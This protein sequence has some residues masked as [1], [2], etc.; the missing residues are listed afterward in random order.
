MSRPKIRLGSRQSHNELPTKEK[1][2]KAR[3][4]LVLH[5]NILRLRKK[6]QAT[7]TKIQS[8][9]SIMVKGKTQEEEARLSFEAEDVLLNCVPV[10]ASKL[11]RLTREAAVERDPEA[12]VGDHP[13]RKRRVL[14]HGRAGGAQGSNQKNE[15]CN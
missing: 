5:G 9:K 8:S 13:K 1:I 10:S 6:K 11:G 15:L 12:G 2:N 7:K 4:T 3:R 14:P